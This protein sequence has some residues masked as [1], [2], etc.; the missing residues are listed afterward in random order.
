MKRLLLLAL[1][2]VMV[3]VLMVAPVPAQ[4]A[5]VNLN[6][7]TEQELDS[8]PGIG[9][10]TAAKI[11]AYRDENGPFRRVE[12]LLEVSG[13]GE[14]KLQNLRDLVTVDA[15]QPEKP[16]DGVAKPPNEG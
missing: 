10:A 11:I 6:T 7:A 5:K 16:A 1:S 13:I 3:G 4:K 9:P 8:L 12:D 14:K 2:V 15:P